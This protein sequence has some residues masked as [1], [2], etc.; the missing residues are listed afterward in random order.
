MKSWRRL[1]EKAQ[2]QPSM[3]LLDKKSLSRVRKISSSSHHDQNIIFFIITNQE[4]FFLQLTISRP[5]ELPGRQWGTWPT[6][7]E[8]ATGI[9]DVTNYAFRH[10][11]SNKLAASDLLENDEV[12]LCHAPDTRRRDYVDQKSRKAKFWEFTNGTRMKWLLIKKTWGW[13]KRGKRSWGDR[14]GC[15]K[16]CQGAENQG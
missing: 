8:N 14:G 15:R 11:M 4:M 13:V 5:F 12:A 9:T 3:P 16:T 7:K 1:P 2:D 6:L 10:S